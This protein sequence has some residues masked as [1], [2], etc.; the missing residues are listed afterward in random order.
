M[1]FVDWCG[2][3][4]QQLADIVR[5]S[6]QAAQYGA[7]QADFLVPLYGSTGLQ[8]AQR[9]RAV[10][11]AI[12]QLAAHGLVENSGSILI[13]VNRAGRDLAEDMTT[14][15]HGICL[16]ELGS[17]ERALLQAVNRLSQRNADEYAWLETVSRESLLAEIGEIG[18]EDWIAFTLN[19]LHA[20]DLVAVHTAFGGFFDVQATYGGLVWENRRAFTLESRFIDELVGEW[21]TTS[22]DFKRELHTDTADQKAEL[23]KDLIGLANT[24]ASGRRWL[25]IGFDDKTR[26]YHGPPGHKLTQNH[27]E[28]LANEYTAPTVLLRYKVIHYRSGPVGKLEVLRDV[29]LVPHRVKRAVGDRKRIREGQVFVRHGSQTAEPDPDELQAIGDEAARA[30]LRASR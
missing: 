20:I 18:E 16:R 29:C 27:L 28:Q 10:D 14:L 24:Q 15:W 26:A 25:I 22:V 9:K 11:Q 4:L 13:Q 30:K 2:F 7:T 3:V 8:D 12:S 17:R 5:R 19:E 6:P 23:V 21:E 1:D